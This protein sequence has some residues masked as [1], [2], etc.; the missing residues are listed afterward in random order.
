VKILA[1]DLST[2]TGWAVIKDDNLGDFGV[3]E[4]SV[5]NFNVNG[6]PEKMPEYPYNIL[7]AS[8]KMAHKVMELWGKYK[9]DQV[10]AENT[11]RG[12]NRHTQR[13]LEFTHKAVLENFRA[14]GVK[15]HYLDPSEWRK[16][17]ELRMSKEDLKNNRQV[18][19]GKK[20]GRVTKKHLSVRAANAMYGLELKIK[21]NDIADAICLGRA[22][23]KA[24]RPK[25]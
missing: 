12:K 8:N 4:I 5:P 10:V 14:V 6:Y 24:K 17:L 21:D 7:D 18:S 23:F 19:A 25:K 1:L 15:V 13:I 2:S 11:V 3:I 16:L 9:P 22:F 20:R